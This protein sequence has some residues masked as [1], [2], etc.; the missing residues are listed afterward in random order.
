MPRAGPLAK[1][2]EGMSG[3]RRRQVAV[4]LGELLARVHRA[5][6]FHRDLYAKHVLVG[7]DDVVHLIDWQRARRAA[8]VPRAARIRDLATLHATL[9]DHLA[10]PRE[11]LAFLRAYAG[12]DRLTQR[13][14]AREVQRETKRLLRHRHIREKRQLPATA[15]AWIC[16]D[17]QAL[18]ITPALAELYPGEPPTE[19]AL[20]HQPLPPAGVE[21]RRWVDL[22]GERRGLLARRRGWPGLACLLRAWLT[23]RPIV[24]RH[25]RR[26]TLLWRLERHGVPAPRVLAAG[27]RRPAPWRVDSFLLVEPLSGTTS[28]TQWLARHS[29]GERAALLARVGEML[30][31]LHEG[32]CYLDRAIALISVQGEGVEALPVLADHEGVLARRA[33]SRR[34]ARRDLDRLRDLLGETDFCSVQRGYRTTGQEDGP[35][36]RGPSPPSL[37]QRLVRRCRRW[38]VRADWIDF[39][40][41]DWPDRIMDVAVTDRFSAK[42]GRSTGR[43]MLEAAGSAPR[44]L[45][46]YLKRH[47]RLPRWRG[48]LAALWPGGDWSPAMQEYNHLEW[49]R[50]QGVPVPATVAAGETIGPGGMLSSFLAVEELTG[51]LPLHE[52]IPQARSQLAPA[53]FRRWKRGLVVELARLTRLLHDRRHFHKDLYLCHFFVHQDDIARVPGEPGSSV[54]GVNAWR[55]RVFLIDLHRLGRHRWTWAWWQCKDLAQLLY[56]SAVS[57]VTVRDRV[58]FWRHYRGCAARRCW[59]WLRKAILFKWR[60]YRRHNARRRM[61]RP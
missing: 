35:V 61:K 16:L 30:A 47:Y 34:R 51:M 40:G 46:V 45:V 31:R 24:S 2:L 42:Q 38:V 17:G 21:S 33:P 49:A 14:L 37:W 43:W 48:L 55:G 15:Q 32:C 56:S 59:R 36:S 22:P 27:Q 6:F 53:D 50:K 1:A 12:P 13:C 18:C 10:G 25:Q 52:A 44:R 23:R 11:R 4:R 41:P 39:A 28:L 3:W 57:G 26:A 19:L 54:P 20:E 7:P 58:A 60:L 8:V 29:P 5:G 9:A